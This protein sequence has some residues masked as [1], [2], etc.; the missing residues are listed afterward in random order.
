MVGE[1]AEQAGGQN[2]GDQSGTLSVESGT[3][4]DDKD[5]GQRDDDERRDHQRRRDDARLFDGP[6][7]VIVGRVVRAAVH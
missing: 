6:L 3:Q 7:D 2:G 4:S 1:H 5:D